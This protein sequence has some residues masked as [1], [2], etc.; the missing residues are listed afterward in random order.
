MLF[1]ISEDNIEACNVAKENPKVVQ[2]LMHKLLSDDNI[3]EY[4][5]WNSDPIK[6]SKQG[7]LAQIESYD[8]EYQ[9]SYHLSWQELDKYSNEDDVDQLSWNE[10]FQHML[11]T[12]DSCS[13]SRKSSMNLSLYQLANKGI[14]K[15]IIVLVAILSL[16]SYLWTTS[17]LF[18]G[19]W[20]KLCKKMGRKDKKGNKHQIDNDEHT[21]LLSGV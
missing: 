1:S 4:I 18:K 5:K 6:M 16:T 15:A 9:K 3:N 7:A 17:K 12:I 19:A 13:L 10:I 11:D 21:T 8:C 20:K 14:I 2:R